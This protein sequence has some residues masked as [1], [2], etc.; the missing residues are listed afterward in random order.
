MPQK[1]LSDL[2]DSTL[3]RIVDG[4]V[5]GRKILVDPASGGFIHGEDGSKVPPY[6]TDI[7]AVQQAFKTLIK[8]GRLK[9][10]GEWPVLTS[11][12]NYRGKMESVAFLLLDKNT[13]LKPTTGARTW[14]V[15]KN[16]NLAR[17]VSELIVIYFLD[18][19]HFDE[20]IDMTQS[21]DAPTLDDDSSDNSSN[22]K[23]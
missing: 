10:R 1:K 14:A 11:R 19:R 17:A 21:A 22:D 2:S 7:T 8:D 23:Q 3:D 4:I 6:S 5:D 13:S 9:V 18:N 12:S 15:V 16:G 20:P